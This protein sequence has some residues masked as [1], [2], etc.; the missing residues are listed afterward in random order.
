MDVMN[1]P[2]V[3]LLFDIANVLIFYSHTPQCMHHIINF[4]SDELS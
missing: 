3:I 2:N 1:D 4:G